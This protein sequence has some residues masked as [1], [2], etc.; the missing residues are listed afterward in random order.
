MY[1][2]KV[3]HLT[4]SS[5]G[6]EVQKIFKAFSFPQYHKPHH[7]FLLKMLFI[8]VHKTMI[9]ILSLKKQIVSTSRLTIISCGLKQIS[10]I[11]NHLF[12]L[13]YHHSL[14]QSNNL[15]S[16]APFQFIN[17]QSP[18][19]SPV[20]FS[21]QNVSRSSF[22]LFILYQCNNIQFKIKSQEIHSRKI[23][24]ETKND[25]RTSFTLEQIAKSFEP[26]SK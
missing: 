18:Y 24:N 10:C 17:S 22:I 3:F 15:P 2:L 12:T 1:I 6:M 14:K 23:R 16:S 13:K 9:F 26:E 11:L 5:S 20:L 21:L 7:S 19:Q 4:H 8:H 25:G